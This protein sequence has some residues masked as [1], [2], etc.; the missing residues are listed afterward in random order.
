MAIGKLDENVSIS[1]QIALAD[2]PALK[3]AGF[4]AIINNRPDGEEFGQ[5]DSA[6]MADAAD[7]AGLAYRH[8]PMSG[9]VTPDML[10]ATQAALAELPGPVLAYCKS[11]TRSAILW[12]AVRASE[13]GTDGVIDRAA[14]AGVDVAMAR[15]LFDAVTR[16]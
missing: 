2:L 5:P 4:A 6:T 7:A 12:G 3:Q 9:G 15:P 11:G 10:E 16:R 13:L 1:P 8:I 14:D